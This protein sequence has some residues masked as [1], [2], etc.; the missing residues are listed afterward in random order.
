MPAFNRAYLSLYFF[1]F[2]LVSGSEL[3]P[4]DP[5]PTSPAGVTVPTAV[6]ISNPGLPDDLYNRLR[7][8]GILRMVIRIRR[9]IDGKTLP[10]TGTRDNSFSVK[11]V[12][13]PIDPTEHWT[14][15]LGTAITYDALIPERFAIVPP[16][17]ERS[18]PD[19]HEQWD[20]AGLGMIRFSSLQQ[21]L[22]IFKELHDA[23]PKLVIHDGKPNNLLYIDSIVSFFERLRDEKKIELKFNYIL[24]YNIFGP[25]SEGCGDAGGHVQPNLYCNNGHL[26][27]SPFQP[28]EMPKLP[29][30]RHRLSAKRVKGAPATSKAVALA[31]R[32]VVRMY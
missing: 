18:D 3:L 25:M 5:K 28:V 8:P 9:R 15:Y 32:A 1:M 4:R 17:V 22:E 13:P 16:P 21:K 11:K 10:L 27:P 26:F 12:E 14:L 20:R 29:K 23:L 24:W 19:N 7:G 2:F 31:P 6:A 30:S